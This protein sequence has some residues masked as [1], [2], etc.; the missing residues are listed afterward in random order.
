MA[1]RMGFDRHEDSIKTVSEVIAVLCGTDA[2][3]ISKEDAYAS[4]K[5]VS[6]IPL[7][8]ELQIMIERST[9]LPPMVCPPDLVT[10]NYESPYLTHNESQI[11]GRNNSHT[12]DIC[13]D[14]INIQNHTALTLDKD[15]LNTVDEEPSYELDTA[16]KVQEWNTFLEQSREIYRLMIASGNQFYLTN[17]VD[18]R[19]RLYAMGYH[20]TTQGT[21]YKKASIEL[22]KQEVVTGVPPQ[23]K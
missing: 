5:I 17:R 2:Y 18:K 22:A 23:T 9:Y 7:S 14:V 13:L 20:V 1:H 12:G 16:E 8:N 21:P 3:D 10:N 4:L 15:F 11:L 6:C 19:G